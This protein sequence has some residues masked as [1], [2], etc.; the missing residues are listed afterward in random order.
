MTKLTH[1]RELSSHGNLSTKDTVA[2]GAGPSNLSLAALARSKTIPKIHVLEARSSA[3]WHPG[4]L[5]LRSRLQGSFLRD[6]VTPI[7]PR[8]EYSFLNFLHVKRRLNGFL[9]MHQDSPLRTEFSEYIEWVAEQVSTSFSD[10]VL[11]VSFDGDSF[12]VES[13]RGARQTKNIVVGSGATPSAPNSDWLELRNVW[14]TA[15]H[16]MSSRN[17]AGKRVAIIGGGQSAAE[18]FLHLLDNP[19]DHPRELTWFTGRNGLKPRDESIFTDIYF[20]PSYGRYFSELSAPRKA[21]AAT[22]AHGAISG[23]SD[24]V[25]REIY[26]RMY[27]FNVAN[28]EEATISIVPSSEITTLEQS[29][30]DSVRM[31]VYDIDRESESVVEVDAAILAT[32]YQKRIPKYLSS[33][34]PRL[35]VSDESVVTDGLG[36]AH[37]DGPSTNG[38]YIHSGPSSSAGVG[39]QSLGLVAWRSARILNDIAGKEIFDLSS[40]W[41][42]HRNN[43]PE[44]ESQKG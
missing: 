9:A 38:V 25:L 5:L 32:G 24:E 40:E 17:I 22:R 15:E 12:I 1:Q 34:L 23:V 30:D 26:S 28:F 18:V 11:D 39:G 33:I 3:A 7:D 44:S 35:Q 16:L 36:R 37:F 31:T 13:E 10:R 14:H 2:I 41:S 8:S 6:L 29:A 19:E 21:E 42:A 27:T 43:V 20:Q 4:L